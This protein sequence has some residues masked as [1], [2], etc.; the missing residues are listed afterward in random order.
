MRLDRALVA[1]GLAPSR[2]RAAQL[3]R[4]GVVRING[5]AAGKPGQEVAADADLTLTENPIPWVSRAALKLVHALD[6]LG[7]SPEGARARDLGASTGG[8]T[9]VLLARG[10]A[11]VTALDVGCDQI[12]PKLRGDPRVTVLEGTNAKDATPALV[13]TPDWIV[14]DISFISLEKALPASLAAARPGGRLVSL[15]KPQFEV[16]PGQVG[17]GGIVKDAHLRTA[18]RDRIVAFVEASG[19]SVTDLATSP[20]T[21]SD[22]NTE[23]LLAALKRP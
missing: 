16:G 3:I 6:R 13:G 18:A 7:L 12:A 2:S 5:A 1:A 17:K 22:G 14:S 9:E 10:A 8:F 20:I 19:W 11:H 23:Y 15:V 21:G 4:A